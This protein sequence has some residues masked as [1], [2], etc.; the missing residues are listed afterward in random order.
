LAQDGTVGGQPKYS[1][2]PV[3]CD[4]PKAA[5]KVVKVLPPGSPLCPNR[6]TGIEIPYAGVTNPHIECAAP[7]RSG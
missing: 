1:S 2:K 3:S 6:T 7:V 5:L 4:S